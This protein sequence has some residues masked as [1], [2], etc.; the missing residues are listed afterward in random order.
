[1]KENIE[2]V[3]S[4][5]IDFQPACSLLVTD[6][7]GYSRRIN[8]SSESPETE[9]KCPTGPNV[10]VSVELD[11]NTGEKDKTDVAVVCQGCKFRGNGFVSVRSGRIEQVR[12]NG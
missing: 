1:M 4:V 6:S 7:G 9:I 5:N 3:V 2:G 12:K 8:F 11:T 10:L